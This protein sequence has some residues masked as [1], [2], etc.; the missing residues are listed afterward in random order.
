MPFALTAPSALS[1]LFA[2]LSSC[3]CL[4]AIAAN[5]NA[6]EPFASVAT[7]VRY[8]SVSQRP[9]KL[10][11]PGKFSDHTG[12]ER[13]V[14]RIWAPFPKVSVSA[15]ALPCFSMAV[16]SRRVSDEV[17][18]DIL[19]AK[20]VENS[21]YPCRKRELFLPVA[22]VPRQKARLPELDGPC[23]QSLLG[24]RPLPLFADAIA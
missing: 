3:A 13:Y 14:V 20:E 10:L 2:S 17:T 8:I 5:T 15:Y 7:S 22:N 23:H 6:V 12:S 1:D 18:T 19:L 21:E 4:P 16:Y 9:S 11:T 24:Q